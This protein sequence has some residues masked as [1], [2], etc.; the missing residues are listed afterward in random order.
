ME[1][2]TEGLVGKASPLYAAGGSTNICGMSGWGYS[3]TPILKPTFLSLSFQG[4]V[5]TKLSKPQKLLMGLAVADSSGI[6][7]ARALVAKVV[8]SKER[9][10]SSSRWTSDWYGCEPRGGGGRDDA[11]VPYLGPL[12]GLD[13]AWEGIQPASLALAMPADLIWDQ[14]V[15]WY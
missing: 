12:I 14:A 8:F 6:H 10:V 5:M 7:L 9:K 4:M 2:G 11:K 3:D 15:A 1:T 13:I